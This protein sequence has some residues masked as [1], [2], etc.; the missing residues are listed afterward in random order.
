MIERAVMLV[1]YGACTCRQQ[2]S[3]P[4]I[5]H[6][7]ATGPPRRERRALR[8]IKQHVIYVILTIPV[9]PPACPLRPHFFIWVQPLKPAERLGGLQHNIEVARKETAEC[10]T[11]PFAQV[12][13]QLLYHLHLLGVLNV[14]RVLPV[15][16]VFAGHLARA[17]HGQR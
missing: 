16:L 9:A 17:E 2:P 11:T 7:E 4:T 14:A 12:L 10:F 3:P 1:C 13:T 8:L 15:P 6:A 5:V